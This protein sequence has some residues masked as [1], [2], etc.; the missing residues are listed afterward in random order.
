MAVDVGGSRCGSLTGALTGWV[1]GWGCGDAGCDRAEGG[2]E[3]RCRVAVDVGAGW[4]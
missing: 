2:R 4:Q 1:T 3:A